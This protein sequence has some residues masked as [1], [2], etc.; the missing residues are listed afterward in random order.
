VGKRKKGPRR[1]VSRRGKGMFV[2]Y[3]SDSIVNV[4]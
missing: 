3:V 1:G 2:D 4:E